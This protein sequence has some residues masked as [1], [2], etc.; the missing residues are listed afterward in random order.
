MLHLV[1]P[2]DGSIAGLVVSPL[3]DLAKLQ[4]C[5]RNA[6]E[7]TKTCVETQQNTNGTRVA[8]SASSSFLHFLGEVWYSAH[9]NLDSS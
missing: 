9:D 1:A 3:F 4:T 8:A 6:N 5:V 2:T 7:I